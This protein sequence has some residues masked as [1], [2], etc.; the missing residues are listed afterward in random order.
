MAFGSLDAVLFNPTAGGTTDW[1]YSSAVTG[2]QSP[3]AAGAT[4]SV[5]YYYR[6]YSSDLTQWEEGYGAWNSGTSVLART[7]VLFNSAGNT[8]KINFTNPPF[9]AIVAPTAFFTDAAS[10]LSGTIAQARLGSGSGGA[11]LK[12]LFDDQSYKTI[13]QAYTFLG[14]VDASASASIDFTALDTSTYDT[15]IFMIRGLVPAT[16]NASL[17]ARIGT[18]STTWQ[19]SSYSETAGNS[20]AVGLFGQSGG[21]AAVPNTAGGGVSG[22]VTVHNLGSTSAI[23]AFTS[24]TMVVLGFFSTSVLG[25]TMV[26][27]WGTTGTAGTGV[28]FLF[29]PGNISAGR[30][31]VF[32]VKAS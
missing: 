7:T 5:V 23:K 19:S 18:G 6:A 4:N 28:R 14:K 11:G 15:F 27:Y 24:D 29:S 20:D 12:A 16:N 17:L 2:Y 10:I 21:R 1:T 32:G 25:N 13:S 31:S 3:A 22:I 30:I 9:V 8:S 26:G